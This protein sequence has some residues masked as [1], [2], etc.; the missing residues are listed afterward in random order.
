MDIK[1]EPIIL[2]VVTIGLEKERLEVGLGGDVVF[3][4]KKSE[5]ALSS[6][7]KDNW[8]SAN[9]PESDSPQRFQ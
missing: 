4:E 6:S 8:F 3:V 9:R 7:G 5:K 2:E 1:R